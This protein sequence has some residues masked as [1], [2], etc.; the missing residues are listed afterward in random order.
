[1]DLKKFAVE[2]TGVL[3]LRGPDRKPLI[4]E[5]K[6]PMTVTLYGP[7]SKQYAIAQAVKQNSLFA[8]MMKG[9]PAGAA[10]SE[11]DEAIAAQKKALEDA[12]FLARV[13]KEFSSNVE[14]EGLK[15]RELAKAIYADASIGFI[16]EDVTKHLA[17]WSNFY[18]GSLIA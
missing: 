5:D 3:A 16:A 7:G 8:K 11:E 18:K 17:G 10:L 15:G 6:L 14:Y 9:E 1:M 2:E 13:T 12:E 4:G